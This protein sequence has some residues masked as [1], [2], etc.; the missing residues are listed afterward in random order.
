MF[1]RDTIGQEDVKRRLIRSVQNNQIAHAQLFTGPEGSGKFQL[2]LAY[3]RYI[4]CTHRGETDACGSC[5]S[6]QQYNKLGH[7]DLHFAFPIIKKGNQK[8]CDQYLAEWRSFIES[9]QG[10]YFNLGQWMDYLEVGN[11]QMKIFTEEGNEIIRK[12]SL[13]GYESDYKILFIWEPELLH[14]NTANK[15]LKLIE[16]PY[17]KTIILLVTDNPEWILPTILSRTQTIPLRSIGQADMA[18]ALQSRFGLSVEEAQIVAHLSEGNFI[19]AAENIHL[20]NE[21]KAYFDLF[22]SLMRLAY[23]RKIRELRDWTDEVAGLGREKQKRFLRYCQRMVRENFIYN[24]K[25]PEL[26]YM[27]SHEKDFSAR[28]APFIT[29]RNIVE[30]MDELATAET[31]VVQNVG[32]KL[33]FFDLSV[34]MILLLKQ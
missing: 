32:A 12:L 28:F 19:K 10:S 7:P 29:E 31:D 23:G 25:Q 18:A 1:F 6:C 20:S 5:P 16:E 3:A 17:E 24:L 30:I 14:E 26:N 11:S 15:L 2:A 13:K 8:V 21:N 33:I 27:N 4:Q 22:V 9:K 34:K